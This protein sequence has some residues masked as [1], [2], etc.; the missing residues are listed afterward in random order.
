MIER[1]LFFTYVRPLNNNVPYVSHPCGNAPRSLPHKRPWQAVYFAELH[2]YWSLYC[3]VLDWRISDVSTCVFVYSVQND[4][5]RLFHRCSIAAPPS[6]DFSRSFSRSVILRIKRA[7]MLEV[8]FVNKERVKMR[9]ILTPPLFAH[10]VFD[11]CVITHSRWIVHNN[12]KCK[13]T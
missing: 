11:W 9:K 1:L 7:A 12:Y 2:Y 10:G 6:Q 4:I 3:A 5:R 13:K 8:Y